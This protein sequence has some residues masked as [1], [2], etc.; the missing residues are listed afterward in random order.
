MQERV[1]PYQ[2]KAWEF[3]KKL[4]FFFVILLTTHLLVMLIS[5]LFM[6]GDYKL[7][8]DSFIGSL[9]FYA[10]MFGTYLG[11]SIFENYDRYTKKFKL[12]DKQLEIE[13][14]EA[15]RDCGNG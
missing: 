12:E 6:I 8:K 15:I 7:I 1:D 13:K 11:K 9:P 5:A 10:A 2:S 4:T 3:S 14:I